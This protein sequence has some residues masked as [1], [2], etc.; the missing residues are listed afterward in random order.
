[1]TD[2]DPLKSKDDLAERLEKARKASQPPE[3]KGGISDPSSGVGMAMRIGTEMVAS[4]IVGLAIGYGLDQWLG[5]RPWLMIVFFFL[6]SAAGM[7][8]VYRA[9]G[10]IGASPF[11]RDRSDDQTD[12]MKK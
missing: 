10:K 4:L 8:S 2:N 11:D 9:A 12:G 3:K 5:T 7:M 1:M 6:G